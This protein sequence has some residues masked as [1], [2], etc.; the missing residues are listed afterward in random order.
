MLEQIDRSAEWVANV[1]GR[2]GPG[3]YKKGDTIRRARLIP[4]NHFRQMVR[5]G[6]IVPAKSVK[7]KTYD[8]T[9]K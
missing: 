8:T 4:F 7:T 5:K 3:R 6:L 1:D 2:L 9:K